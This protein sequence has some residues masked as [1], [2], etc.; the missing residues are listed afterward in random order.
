MSTILEGNTEALS[1]HIEAFE[2]LVTNNPGSRNLSQV[3]RV[4]SGIYGDGRV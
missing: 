1:G 3:P 2:N 4:L